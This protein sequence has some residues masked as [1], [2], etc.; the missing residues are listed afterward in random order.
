MPPPKQAKSSNQ[1]GRI[2][3][4]KQAVEL[5]QIQSIR[6]AADEFDVHFE[7]L[8]RRIHGT[9]SRGDCTPNSRKLTPCEEEAIIQYILDL[10]S[11]GFPPWPRDMQEMAN[12]LLAERDVT[13]VSKNW[14][15]NFINRRLEIQSKFNRKYDHKRA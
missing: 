11:R 6:G 3:L 15:T 5:G 2:L 10:D 7:T 12:L 13:P 14:A 8:R 1:E 9:P 4:T